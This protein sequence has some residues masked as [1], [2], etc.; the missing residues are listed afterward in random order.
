MT[1]SREALDSDDRYEDDWPYEEDYLQQLSNRTLYIGEQIMFT[2]EP[3]ID[4]NEVLFSILD[5]I[6]DGNREELIG[7]L[8][9]MLGWLHK[10]GIMPNISKDTVTSTTL[11]IIEQEHLKREYSQEE[12]AK[13]DTRLGLAVLNHRKRRPQ[14]RQIGQRFNILQ[15]ILSQVS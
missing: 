7:Q 9:L 11:W 2:Q 8:I 6:H 3:Q 4:P 15:S 5:H 13:E 12:W 10:G 14:C 1:F